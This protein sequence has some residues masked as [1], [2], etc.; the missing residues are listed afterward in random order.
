[1][2][3]KDRVLVIGSMNSGFGRLLFLEGDK[4]CVAC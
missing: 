3:S 1:M 2:M 4:G